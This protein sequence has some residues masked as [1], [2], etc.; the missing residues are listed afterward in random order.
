MEPQNDKVR[1]DELVEMI[2]FL[3]DEIK[4][5]YESEAGDWK[6]DPAI[7]KAHALLRKYGKK[8]K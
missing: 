2:C 7:R 3:V 5:N 4:A 1:E 6:F 8:T